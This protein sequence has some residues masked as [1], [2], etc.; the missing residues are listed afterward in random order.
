MSFDNLKTLLSNLI[1]RPVETENIRKQIV[2]ETKLKFEEIV[3]I[4]NEI[5][6]VGGCAI[7]DATR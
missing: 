7:A 3:E 2:E 6:L 1:R 4:C 5:I